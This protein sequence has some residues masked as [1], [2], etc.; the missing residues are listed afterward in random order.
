MIKNR[1]TVAFSLFTVSNQTIDGVNYTA[2]ALAIPVGTVVQ[3]VSDG[4][5]WVKIN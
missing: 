5:N 2:S 3:I 4:A 1:G